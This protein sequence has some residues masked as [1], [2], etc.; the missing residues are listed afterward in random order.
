MAAGSRPVMEFFF[1]CLL[2]KHTLS[3]W[4]KTSEAFV[5]TGSAF[6]SYSY[7][8]KKYIQMVPLGVLTRILWIQMHENSKKKIPDHLLNF[9]KHL[10][11]CRFEASHGI[12]FLSSTFQH[13]LLNW[14]KISSILLK[15][16]IRVKIW[17]YV[18][19]KPQHTHRSYTFN[20]KKVIQGHTHKIQQKLKPHTLLDYKL[21]KTWMKLHVTFSKQAY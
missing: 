3:S 13:T 12:F 7:H 11:G 1:F 6:T 21:S 19:V 17:E 9:C 2:I 15:P 5:R 10:D 14:S 18:V 8:N 20:W 4:F 16:Y